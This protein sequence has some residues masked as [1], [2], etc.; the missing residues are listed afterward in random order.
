MKTI[1]KLNFLFIAI[2]L[3]SLPACTAKR[4]GSS[5]DTE[6]GAA[7]AANTSS[8]DQEAPDMANTVNEPKIL[9]TYFSCTGNTRSVAVRIANALKADIHEIKPETP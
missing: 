9:V 7:T 8:N 4:S 2:V 1:V 6:T 5:G 3:L